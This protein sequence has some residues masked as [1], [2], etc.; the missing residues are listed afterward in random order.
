ML[1]RPFGGVARKEGS[2]SGSSSREGSQNG[3]AVHIDGLIASIPDGKGEPP[4]R[5]ETVDSVSASDSA[6]HDAPELTLPHLKMLF[7]QLSNLSEYL[8]FLSSHA[9]VRLSEPWQ[10]FFEPG[11]NDHCSS[12]LEELDSR[13][14]KKLR[15]DSVSHAPQTGRTADSENKRNSR[16]SE[17]FAAD[18]SGIGGDVSSSSMMRDSSAGTGS[19]MSIFVETGPA[20]RNEVVGDPEVL[21]FMKRM[22]YDGALG[23]ESALSEDIHSL[24]DP[25]QSRQIGGALQADSAERDD[26]AR[27]EDEIACEENFG[28]QENSIYIRR[29]VDSTGKGVVS[30][31]MVP[32]ISESRDKSPSPDLSKAEDS[33]LAALE[34]PFADEDATIPGFVENGIDTS[35]AGNNLSTGTEITSETMTGEAGEKAEEAEVKD[36]IKKLI[37]GTSATTSQDIQRNKSSASPGRGRQSVGIQDFEVIRVLGKGCA[38]KVVSLSS[39]P[40]LLLMHYS[41]QVLLARSKLN[42]TLYAVKAIHKHHVLA[43]RELQHT[44]TEQSILK[45]M[46]TECDNPFVVKMSF[47]FQDKDNLFLVLDFHPGGDLATQ[48]SRWGR[49]GKDRTRFYAAEIIEG[50]EGLHAAGV[51]YRDLKPENVLLAADG[52]VILTDFGLSKQFYRSPARS[53]SVPDTEKTLPF[54]LHGS[55]LAPLHGTNLGDLD[56]TTVTFCGTAEYL[57]PEV[58]LGKS[59][60]YPVDMWSLGTMIYEMLLGVVG[61]YLLES[62]DV[63]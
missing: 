1:A 8:G 4:I 27:A 31:T 5:A 54:G 7:S 28:Y 9:E 44:L 14:V 18:D 37:P 10:R 39:A 30:P 32:S 42:S 46:A 59:Y 21:E 2:L 38:G 25:Q 6:L 60:T 29:E 61:R 63:R 20:G 19:S 53:S 13:R 57:A 55:S 11:K 50:L 24:P 12:R 58:L 41:C 3:G 48:L 17:R 34:E 51:I 43:H 35:E 36:E 40:R 23:P 52:H 45:K 49:L 22:S 47:S 15:G 16:S 56:E 26:Q 62:Q 33:I